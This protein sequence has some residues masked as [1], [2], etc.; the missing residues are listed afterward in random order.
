MSH[1]QVTLIE[2]VQNHTPQVI[3]VDEIGTQK[4]GRRLWGWHWH[5][6]GL[7]WCPRLVIY[8][9]RLGS[10]TSWLRT[11]GPKAHTAPADCLDAVSG[12]PL[13]PSHSYVHDKDGHWAVC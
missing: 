11:R 6:V 10:D 8:T 2:A 12:G 13:G 7:L 1:V 9:S 4:V 3:V 5:W